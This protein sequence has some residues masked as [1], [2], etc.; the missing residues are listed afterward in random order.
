MIQD[1]YTRSPDDP[2]FKYGVLH[3]SSPIESIITKIKM[4]LGTRQGEIIGDLNFGVG[5]ED[6]VF[7]TRIN[8]MQLEEKLKAQ[9]DTYISE[10]KDYQI[11]PNITFGRENFMDYAII[12]VFVN[13]EKIFG[14]LVK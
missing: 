14:V 7:E 11:T 6:L 8:K 13:N 4:I 5:I 10:S 3:H 2:G 12:D 1:I 9:F